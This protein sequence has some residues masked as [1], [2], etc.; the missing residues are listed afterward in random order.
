MEP[1]LVGTF[2]LVQSALSGVMTIR[3]AEMTSQDEPS[4]TRESLFVQSQVN[5]SP[6]Q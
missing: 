4:L 3:K 1:T 6:V 2:P 5:D